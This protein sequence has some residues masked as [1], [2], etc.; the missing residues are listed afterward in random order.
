MVIAV[1][2]FGQ[3]NV[4]SYGLNFRQDYPVGKRRRK[5]SE[6]IDA[7]SPQ[8]YGQACEKS[9]Q[10]AKLDDSLSVHNSL[11]MMETSGRPTL[12]SR[13][14]CAVESASR[15]SGLPV[16]MIV[17]SPVLDLT[18][19]TTCFLYTGTSRVSF[20]TIDIEDFAKNSPLDSFFSSSKLLQSDYRAAHT[21]DALRLL[22][23]YKFGG[24]YLDID[25]VV[26]NDLTHYKNIVVGNKPESFNGG[27]ITVT[28]NA[29]SFTR[30]HPLP[31]MAM[32]HVKESYDPSCWP[33]IGPKLLP[34]V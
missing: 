23:L 11:F 25:Y 17:F 4:P 20:F 16:V 19:N 28:N 13:Q 5:L 6:R 22:I 8:S 32:K 21:A 1:H 15:R 24:F 10:L 7:P 30:N 29:F 9:V 2:I 27:E 26:L 33:C 14:A 12:N 18:D 3:E 34:V 31:L